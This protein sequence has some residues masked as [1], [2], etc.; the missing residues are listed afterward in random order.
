MKK[1]LFLLST[2]CLITG[3]HW[4]SDEELAQRHNIWVNQRCESYGF[5]QGTDAYAECFRKEWNGYH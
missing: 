5:K 3:C 1:T 2:V 4:Y